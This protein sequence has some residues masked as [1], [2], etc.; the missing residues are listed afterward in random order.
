MVD[1]PLIIKKTLQNMLDIQEKIN[2]NSYIQ[3]SM[4]NENDS[5]ENIVSNR[6]E[7]E[8]KYYEDYYESCD[9]FCY[10]FPCHCCLCCLKKENKNDIVKIKK[11]EENEAIFNSYDKFLKIK[12]NEKELNLWEK[13]L[14]VVIVFFHYFSIAQINSIIYSLL[15][16]AKRSFF[17]YINLEKYLTTNSFSDF[18]KNSNIKDTSQ[19][20]LFYLTSLFTSHLLKMCSLNFL[21]IICFMINSTILIIMR[22]IDYKSPEETKNYGNYQFE[23]FVL[24]V[25]A[26]LVFLYTFTGFIASFPFYI[27]KSYK[28]Y[29]SFSPVLINFIILLSIIVKLVSCQYLKI[30][31]YIL[32]RY[33]FFIH[34]ELL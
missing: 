10:K 17:I 6:I 31:D 5:F 16:E 30:Y 8:E 11:T 28:E 12:E 29:Q 3:I 7:K 21:Y 22:Y 34:L 15:E 33:F 9:L 32:L 27:I 20:N 1:N 14:F 4:E 19:I 23:E 18:I 26:P 24:K 25:C 2:K 13:F